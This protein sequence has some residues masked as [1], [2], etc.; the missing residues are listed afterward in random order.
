MR[1]LTINK[2]SGIQGGFLPERGCVDQ[3]F[4]LRMIV[5]KSLDKNKKVFCGFL[6][7]KKAYDSVLRET[8]WGVLREYGVNGNLLG[9]IQALYEGSEAAVRID[10]RLSDWF[11]INIGVKQGCGMSPWLFN[12]Y[13]DVLLRKALNGTDGVHIGES[14]VPA[15]AYA[16][17]VVVF[18]KNEEQLGRM[19]ERIHAVGKNM[20]LVLNV[21]KCKVLVFE[22][23][24]LVTEC[25][26]L[27]DG[28]NLEQVNEF[29]Y[30]G[31]MMSRDGRI[32][33][34]IERRVSAGC[35]VLGALGTFARNVNVSR[36][37]RLSVYNGVLVPS[38]M[39][40]SECWTWMGKHKRRV[41][42]VKLRYLRGVCGYV[43]RDRVRND[44][45]YEECMIRKNV[46]E[47]VGVS[48]LRWFGHLER[49][50][51]ERLV[52]RIYV[53]EIEGVRLRGRPACKWM[54]VINGVLRVRKFKVGRI[55]EPV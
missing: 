42:A 37:A 1:T 47:R 53:S 2:I 19:I 26:V 38:L 9:A 36:D 10:G 20:N 11:R 13:M 29:V 8:L 15:L 7:V 43:R 34:E 51:S 50:A 4:A 6:D 23:S 28:V 14:I 5:E 12:L 17:D 45:V 24:D 49:M 16:D 40:E 32:D 33:R 54:D 41:T 3:M 55:K 25:N 35:K 46:V 48:Q 21:D 44:L 39:Y 27:V 30:L 22:R 52:K 31:S 18:G